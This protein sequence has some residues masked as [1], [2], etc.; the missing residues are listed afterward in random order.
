MVI[1]FCD[2]IGDNSLPRFC[3]I[4]E[5]LMPWLTILYS[6]TGAACVTLALV[7]LLIWF[8]QPTRHTH[9]AFSITALSVAA[10]TPFELMMARAQSIEQFGRALYWLYLPAGLATLALIWFILLYFRTGRRWLALTVCGLNLAAMILNFVSTPNLDYRQITSLRQV[11]VGAGETATVA[12]GVINPWT[13]I[14]QFSSLLLLVYVLDA[15]IT[16][17][18]RGGRECRRQALLFGGVTGLVVFWTAGYFALV[19]FGLVYSPV[20]ISLPFLL[21]I[22]AMAYELSSEVARSG[23][24]YVAAGASEERLSLAQEA[25]GIGTFDLDFRTGEV[26]WTEH[27]ELIFG[28]PPGGFG[29]KSEHWRERLHPD[30]LPNCEAE[31]NNAINSGAAG[32]HAE[33]RIF[34]VGSGEIRWIDA[35]GRLFYDARSEPMRMLGVN[36]DIT[37]R[38]AAEEAARARQAQLAGIV[39][40]A[41]DAIISID[42]DQNVVIFNAAAEK[43]FQC[44]SSQAVGQSLDHFTPDRLRS[45][46]ADDTGAYGLSHITK[47]SMDLSQPILGLRSTGEEFSIEASISQVEVQGKRTYTLILRDISERSRAEA[48]LRESE[49][50]FSKAFKGNPQPM[51][52]TVFDDGRFLDVNDSFLNMSGFTRNE[53]IGQTALELQLWDT[54]THRDEYMRK[55][56]EDGAIHNLEA[57]FRTKSGAYRQLLSSAELLDL[58]GERCVLTAA[59]DITERSRAEESLRVL[60]GRLI[61]AQEVE[62]S[63]VARELHDDLS[64]RMAVLSIG[65]T[66]LGQQVPD[67]ADDGMQERIQNLLSESK[68]ISTELHR[69]A[70]QLHPSKLDHLGIVA[71]VRSFCAELSAHTGMK[72]DFSNSGFNA[73]LSKEVTLCLFRVVQEAL[74][75]AVKYSGASEAKVVLENTETVVS[76]LVADRGNGFDT[77][78]RKMTSGL[79]FISMRERMRLVNG[80]L[81]IHS[82]PLQGT[83]IEVTV[84]LARSTNT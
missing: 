18:R 21:Y 8:R 57:K 12:V 78:S 84:P 39:G 73:E 81:S 49:Q 65:L 71:A 61:N 2:G 51:A 58:G 15:S 25:G 64:Q 77:N 22:A 79:G 14:G 60:G 6:A 41:M 44:E 55:L 53:V 37:A 40:S 62:R 50:R 9:L 70:Y 38:K 74:H 52:L 26:K 83:T 19:L 3:L 43:M 32:W 75:N 4:D 63:R 11:S 13:L 42:E 31:I 45:A 67:Q 16:L 29:G 7:Q 80:Q 23:A 72:I 27:L 48:A 66:Q 54:P 47:H 59:T 5:D 33:Y 20:L 28:F 17:W 24:L 56:Q 10:V 35:R 69:V 1:H 30:D 76:L 34:P 68:D 36:I 82:S 46:S